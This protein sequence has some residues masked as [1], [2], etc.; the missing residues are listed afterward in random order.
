S[1]LLRPRETSRERR[2]RG[3]PRARRATRP[4]K[5]GRWNERSRLLLIR[6]LMVD[7]VTALVRARVLAPRLRLDH[8]L[9]ARDDLELAGRE[10]L[11]DEHRPVGVLVVLVHLDRAARRRECLAIDGL[12]DRIDVEALGLLDRLLPDVDAEVRGLHRI[13]GDALVTAREV[14][15]L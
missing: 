6:A 14:L 12:A 13:V 5:G 7:P 9:R 3:P 2:P 11:A 8:A 4:A 15:L 10:D 1:A